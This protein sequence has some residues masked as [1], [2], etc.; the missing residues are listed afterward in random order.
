M[1]KEKEGMKLMHWSIECGTHRIYKFGDT[2]WDTAHSF[3]I[4]SIFLNQLGVK[5]NEES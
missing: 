2:M 5:L 3:K 4:L 1:N